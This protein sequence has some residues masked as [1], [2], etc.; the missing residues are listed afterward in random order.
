MHMMVY[1]TNL[2]RDGHNGVFVT[3]HIAS[4]N[5]ARLQVQNNILSKR[6]GTS[7]FTFCKPAIHPSVLRSRQTSS[8][9]VKRLST[10]SLNSSRISSAVKRKS[11]AEMRTSCRLASITDKDS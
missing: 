2:G 3:F 11:F 1:W 6:K 9:F 10:V 5:T 8:S 7:K 4:C